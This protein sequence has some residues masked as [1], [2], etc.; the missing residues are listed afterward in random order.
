[1]GQ[2]SWVGA[3]HPSS[4]TRRGG[5]APARVQVIAATWM[6]VRAAVTTASRSWSRW[7]SWSDRSQAARNPPPK[8]SPAPTVSTTSTAGTGSRRRPPAVTISTDR[9][10]VGHEDRRR[11]AGHEQGGQRGL[12]V[13]GRGD[14]A[15]IIRADLDDVRPRGKTDDPGAP[16]RR[17]RCR[18]RSGVRVEHDQR[19]RR[20]GADQRLDRR[21]HSAPGPARACRR[22]GPRSIRA[23]ARWP[24]RRVER[25]AGRRR[26]VEFEAIG[27][28]AVLVERRDAPSSSD[29]RS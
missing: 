5:S 12:R 18:R 3:V 11:S 14:G 4:S 1:M 9:P 10:A 8:A 25:Q 15:E 24:A 7:R 17:V 6:A 16:G 29:R 23:A 28:H 26:A 19:R 27:R 2:T 22:G 20:H 13:F 21:R